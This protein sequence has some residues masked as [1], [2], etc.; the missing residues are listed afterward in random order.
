[1]KKSTLGRLA[2]FKGLM[3]R[4]NKLTET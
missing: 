3:I 1:M 4:F 2:G